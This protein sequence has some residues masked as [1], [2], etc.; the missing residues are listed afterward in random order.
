MKVVAALNT[1]MQIYI[2]SIDCFNIFAFS[3][4]LLFSKLCF[5]RHDTTVLKAILLLNFI[6]HI[7]GFTFWECKQNL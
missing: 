4:L 7:F 6:L 3:I 1:L 5:F 2:E